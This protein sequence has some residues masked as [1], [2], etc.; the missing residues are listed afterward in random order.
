M[1]QRSRCCRHKPFLAPIL[2][3]LLLL[4]A[5]CSSRPPEATLVNN[6]RVQYVRANRGH[7]IVVKK[8]DKTARIRLVGVY[9][10]DPKIRRKN[11]IVN[12]ADM[13]VST[14][15]KRFA[16]KDLEVTL[17]FEETDPRGRY[18]GQAHFGGE[19]IAEAMIREGLLAVYTE[20]SF[21]RSAVYHAAEAEARNAVRGIWSSDI[22][23]ERLKALRRTWSSA[24]A[25][26][27]GD[28][29]KD[30]FLG[31]ESAP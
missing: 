17:E 9:A 30:P 18:L 6:D 20:Y 8:G 27:F 1:A 3:A 21:R 14:W 24:H 12:F 25:R 31:A 7:E 5:A 22:A 23:V 19:D 13:A 11:E 2:G 10:F 4:T 16:G 29:A 28:P 26:R 15:D